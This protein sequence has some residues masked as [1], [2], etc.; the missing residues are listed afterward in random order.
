MFGHIS[1]SFIKKPVDKECWENRYVVLKVMFQPGV[2]GS[3]FSDL[4]QQPALNTHSSHRV[5]GPPQ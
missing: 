3:I 4:N 2:S 1:S 5:T